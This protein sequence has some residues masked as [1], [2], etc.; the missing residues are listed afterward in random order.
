M[1]AKIT[2][3]GHNQHQAEGMAVYHEQRFQWSSQRLLW[4]IV[5]D[6]L[7]IDVRIDVAISIELVLV[8]IPETASIVGHVVAPVGAILASMGLA[9]Y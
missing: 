1:I 7:A 9:F 3:Y 2:W 5:N 8:A 6:H 4:Q